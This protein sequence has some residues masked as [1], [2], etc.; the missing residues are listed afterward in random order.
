MMSQI[1]HRC[2]CSVN[3]VETKQFLLTFSPA[4]I[5]EGLFF[6]LRNLLLDISIQR[7]DYEKLDIQ[8]LT[9]F[10]YFRNHSHLCA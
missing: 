3:W 6:S 8:L 2:V 4:L 1:F 7:L 10:V 9:F 5:H